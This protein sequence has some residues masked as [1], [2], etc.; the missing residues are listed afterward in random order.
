MSRRLPTSRLSRSVSP[1]MVD[2][3]SRRSVL[4]QAT[5]SWSNEVTDVLMEANGERRSWDTAWSMAVR[6]ASVSAIAFALDASCWCRRAASAMLSWPAKMC[7]TRRPSESSLSPRS[8]STVS[9]P[10]SSN[11]VP[12]VGEVGMGS[13][14]PAS[15]NHDSPSADS[16]AAPWRSNTARTCSRRLLSGSASPTSVAVVR[17]S[18]SASARARSASPERRATRSTSA[19][20][21]PDTARNTTRTVTFSGSPTVKVW[22]GGTKNQLVI[23]NAMT[24]ATRPTAIPPSALIATTNANATRS[25]VASATPSPSA[26]PTAVI[27]GNPT[28]P[29][30]N[31]SS[32]RRGVMTLLGARGRRTRGGESSSLEMTCRS[33]LPATRSSCATIDPRTRW[34]HRDRRLAPTTSCVAFSDWA[35]PRR[36]D[37]T[38]LP[39]TSW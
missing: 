37:A 39:T 27:S 32:L 26:T 16:T 17:A 15:T 10:S 34:D 29:S 11:T 28:N 30:A 2:S 1:S 6:R 5:S 21:V 31:A 19:L 3:N 36:A 33:M 4:L 8:T 25:S 14:A 24:A 22:N 13:P 7:T 20:T 18:A 12:S 38:S 35:N 23:R 9:A